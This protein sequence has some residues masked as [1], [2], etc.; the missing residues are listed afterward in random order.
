MSELAGGGRGG[1]A[2]AVDSGV[3]MEIENEEGEAYVEMVVGMYI[4]C[5][6]LRS[7]WAVGE[8]ARC[9]VDGRF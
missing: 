4:A 3:M 2:V 8:K 6:H 1:I 5:V 9:A 7:V